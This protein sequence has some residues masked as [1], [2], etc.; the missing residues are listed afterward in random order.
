MFKE[1]ID[2]ISVAITETESG[3]FI[4]SKTSKRVFADKKSVRQSEF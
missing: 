1:V 4:E 3:G 2:L